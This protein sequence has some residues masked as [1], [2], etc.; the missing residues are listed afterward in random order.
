LIP[1]NLCAYANVDSVIVGVLKRILIFVA[2][3]GPVGLLTFSLPRRT[4]GRGADR[5]LIEDDSEK[6]SLPLSVHEQIRV[7]EI[8]LACWRNAARQTDAGVG[9]GIG[10]AYWAGC[11]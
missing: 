6:T 5:Q 11:C 1:Y 9:K 7:D 4:R 2:R 8:S 3:V 10:G